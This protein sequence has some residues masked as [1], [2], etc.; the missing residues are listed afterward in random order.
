LKAWGDYVSDIRP[1]LPECP[2]VLIRGAILD[3]AVKFCE[4]SLC[5]QDTMDVQVTVSERDITLSTDDDDILVVRPMWV[6]NEDGG[7]L[8][9]KVPHWL[10]RNVA[11]WRY[12]T[13]TP[14]YYTMPLRGTMLWI[15]PHTDTAM[16][17]DLMV[18]LKPGPD[19]IE[20]PDDLYYD[21]REAVQ[22]GAIAALA[23]I[24]NKP[25]TS[26]KL[27][28]LHDTNFNR[29]RDI[30][31]VRASKGNTKA[32]IRVLNNHRF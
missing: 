25:W 17:L 22:S 21:Y 5:W 8:E 18:A 14:K 24:P 31:L 3:A 27:M 20:G 28:V 4:H 10:D 32:P 1:Y 6:G 19:S 30:A 13:G 9:A 7:E 29:W 26:D 2:D 15:V 11:D 12:S 16:T 23:G